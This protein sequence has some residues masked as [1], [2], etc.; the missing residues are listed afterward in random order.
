MFQIWNNISSHKPHPHSPGNL[1]IKQRKMIK[2]LKLYRKVVRICKYIMFD[3][4]KC[5]IG[6]GTGEFI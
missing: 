1:I 4:E 5:E 6:L 2:F 3:I